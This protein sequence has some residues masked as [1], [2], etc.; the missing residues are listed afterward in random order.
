MFSVCGGTGLHLVVNA[1]AE[2]RNLTFFKYMHVCMY[3]WRLGR[4]ENM[5]ELLF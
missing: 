2:L 3:T 4:R 5:S 1:T